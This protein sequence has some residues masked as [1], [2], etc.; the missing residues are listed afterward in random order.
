MNKVTQS[1]YKKKV[2]NLEEGGSGS[3]L[4][5]IVDSHGNK[6]FIEGNGTPVTL[7]KY[8]FSICK[9]SL[10]GTHL[11]LVLAGTVEATGSAIS[12]QLFCTFELPVW[13]M[14]KI[15]PL[16]TTGIIESKSMYYYTDTESSISKQQILRKVNNTLTI[17]N[18]GGGQ[19]SNNMS[20]R[21]QF[22]LLIDSE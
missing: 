15:Y 8:N 5:D 16:S 11:M 7:S 22:D 21:I 10:S 13:I 18:D 14:N 3:E 6:R 4:D 17:T 19:F 1:I 9:W 12:G 2:D 20:F